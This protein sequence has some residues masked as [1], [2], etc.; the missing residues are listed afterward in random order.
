[1]VSVPLIVLLEVQLDPLECLTAH[2]ACYKDNT[3]IPRYLLALQEEEEILLN[4]LIVKLV[5]FSMVEVRL[6]NI[7]HVTSDSIDVFIF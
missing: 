4:E 3:L 2:I 7:H 1:M 6:T 5:M